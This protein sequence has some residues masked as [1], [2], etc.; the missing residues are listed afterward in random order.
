MQRFAS[1]QEQVRKISRR[2]PLY[3]RVTL[4]FG[5]AVNPVVNYDWTQK[6]LVIQVLNE[7]RGTKKHYYTQQELHFWLLSISFQ[8]RIN[9]TRRWCNKYN[10]IPEYGLAWDADETDSRGTWVPRSRASAS[11]WDPTIGLA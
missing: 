3:I 2:K 4:S 1:T 9:F 5:S 6:K 11:S 7:F 10:E 8:V